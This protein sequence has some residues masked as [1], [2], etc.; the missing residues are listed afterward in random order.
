MTGKIDTPLTV[1]EAMA[2]GVPVIL[3][4]LP[5]LNEMLE[6]EAGIAVSPGD[7]EAFVQAILEL[8]GNKERRQEMGIRCR[9]VVGERYNLQ[10]MVQ[11]YEDLYGELA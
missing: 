6:A 2:T 9:R 3:T 10:R 1:L 11:V 4:D 5:P 8:A 7:N